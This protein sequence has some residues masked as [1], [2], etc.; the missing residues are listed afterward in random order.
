MTIPHE[1]MVIG[2]GT[3]LVDGNAIGRDGNEADF[4]GNV[5]VGRVIGT[6]LVG[7]G[8]V[9]LGLGNDGFVRLGC[10]MPGVVTVTPPP[11]PDVPEPGAAV[12]LL[13]PGFWW[14]DVLEPGVPVDPERVPVPPL[15]G[16]LDPGFG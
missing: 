9:R 5:I 6:V 7:V 2:S 10:G 11:P 12:V 14:L 4:V 8:N 1:L 3:M 16:V 13:E 15:A